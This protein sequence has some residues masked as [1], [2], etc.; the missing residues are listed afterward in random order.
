MKK[1]IS[2]KPSKSTS[3]TTRLQRDTAPSSMKT[4]YYTPLSL[5]QDSINTIKA[6]QQTSLDLQGQREAL[7]ITIDVL[8]KRLL[9]LQDKLNKKS[10]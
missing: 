9:Y 10:P 8:Q 4:P 3:T 7:N 5:P 2:D 1:T 6:I